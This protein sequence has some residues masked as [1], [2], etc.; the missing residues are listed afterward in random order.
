MS[1]CYILPLFIKFYSCVLN[2]RELFDH[3]QLYTSMKMKPGNNSGTLPKDVDT[4]F[5]SLE[6]HLQSKV[7]YLLVILLLFIKL[8]FI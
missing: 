6:K 3:Y 8:E 4:F 5:S 2:Y 7:S 1:E